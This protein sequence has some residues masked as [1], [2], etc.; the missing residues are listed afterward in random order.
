[1]GW[2]KRA[3]MSCAQA[4]ALSFQNSDLLAYCKAIRELW[5]R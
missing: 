1:M 4:K 2:A 3:Y 5:R